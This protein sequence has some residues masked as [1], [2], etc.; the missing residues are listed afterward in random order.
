MSSDQKVK[1]VLSSMGRDH[2]S[3]GDLRR[4]SLTL[5]NPPMMGTL[6]TGR[7]RS[8]FATSSVPTGCGNGRVKIERRSSFVRR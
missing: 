4:K 6:Q 3:R 7:R 1:V 8:S 5:D 2:A